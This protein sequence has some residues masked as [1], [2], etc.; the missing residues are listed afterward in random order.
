MKSAK[1][2]GRTIGVLLLLQLAAGLT[3]PFILMRPLVAGAPSFLTAAAEN[4]AQ[5]R[6]G[7]FLAF[8]G[9][10][11]TIGLGIKAFPVFRRYS[12][13]LALWFLVVCVISGVLDAVHGATALAMLSLSREFGGATAD[14]DRYYA[15][16]AGAAA[17]RRSA[18]IVQLI[19][20][21]AWISIFYAACLR[22]A[23][24]PRALAVLGLVGIALQFSG[25]T[26]MMFLGSGVI[27][28]LAVP[29]LPIQITTAV[30]LIIKGF[31]EEKYV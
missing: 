23:L 13:T 5:I 9:S 22:F 6:V 19:G 25:V 14:L 31:R 4:A 17:L 7:V 18:H 27:G 21:G 26:L 20:I 8:V 15:V 2:A 1:K 16:G 24:V 3:F 29:M 30:W 12:G 10:A 28:A 11:L